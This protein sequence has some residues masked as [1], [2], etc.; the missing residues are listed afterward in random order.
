MASTSS[1]E[2][3][4]LLKRKD[5][6]SKFASKLKRVHGR[7]AKRAFH[8]LMRKSSSLRS[9]LKK[10]SREY[11]VDFKMELY[12][13]RQMLYASYANPCRYCKTQL[14]VSN[15]ACDHIIAISNGGASIPENLEM[16]CKT[17]NTRKGPLDGPDYTR[18]VKWVNKQPSYMTKYINKKMAAK[19]IFR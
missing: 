10:R 11:E 9:S 18:L 19:D 1:Q 5:W 6:E 2:L 8:R 16:V 7:Y 13:V 3:L 17:C 14:V 4:P 12:E 15:M